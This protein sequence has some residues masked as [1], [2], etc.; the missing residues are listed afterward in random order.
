[1]EVNICAEMS[2]QVFYIFANKAGN[3]SQFLTANFSSSTQ[4]RLKIWHKDQRKK[5]LKKIQSGAVLKIIIT[6]EVLSITSHW[7]LGISFHVYG[8]ERQGKE[9]GGGVQGIEEMIIECLF[10][11]HFVYIY[12]PPCLRP[13][14]NIINA[15]VQFSSDS[16]IIIWILWQYSF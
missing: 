13:P 12:P 16:T 15:V 9:G 6:V 7:C 14:L 8:R 2:A 10:I 11:L 4:T 3:L 5:T 1:M